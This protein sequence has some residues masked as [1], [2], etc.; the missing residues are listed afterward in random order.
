MGWRAGGGV[1]QSQ[2]VEGEL[3][4]Q[5]VE[6]GAD[7]VDGAVGV[8]RE[9]QCA[10][11]LS[12]GSACGP[13]EQVFVDHAPQGEVGLAG[14]G[15]AYEQIIVARLLGLQHDVAHGF[16]PGSP[17]PACGVGLGVAAGQQEFA[18]W[19]GGREQ[20]EE[21]LYLLHGGAVGSVVLHVVAFLPV[22]EQAATLSVGQFDAD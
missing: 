21:V 10:I 11:G 1:P 19:A 15:R 13:F 7:F 4:A 18:P 3:P 20:G 17:E 22:E 5:H 6:H 14:A 16:G 2:I 9:E 12:G 8:G